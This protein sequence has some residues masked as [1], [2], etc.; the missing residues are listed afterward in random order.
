MAK[1]HTNL[2]EQLRQAIRASGLSLTQLGHTTG[3][4]SG[5]LSR[6]MRGE[7]DLT[8]AATT[9]LCEALDLQLTGPGSAAGA[10]ADPKPKAATPSTPPAEDLERQEKS[11]AK[12]PRSRP[13]KE[14][15]T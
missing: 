9:K 1:R 5:R 4:D 12:K 7:R 15:R 2:E 10:L 6:F 8:L 13:R 14:K 11:T 3:V